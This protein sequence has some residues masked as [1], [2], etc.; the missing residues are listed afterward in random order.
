MSKQAK[1]EWTQD[2][3]L[4]FRKMERA[5]TDAPILNHFNPAKRINLQTDG[6]GIA[7]AGILNQYDGFRILRPVNFNSQKCTGAKLI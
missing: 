7:M 4:A 5:F 3:E 2:A 6:N 1:W